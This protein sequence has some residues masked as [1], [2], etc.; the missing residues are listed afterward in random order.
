MQ[1]SEGRVAQTERIASTEAVGQNKLAM[2]ECLQNNSDNNKN[3]KK[4][5]KK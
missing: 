1:T 2:L 3:R 5:K 4:W